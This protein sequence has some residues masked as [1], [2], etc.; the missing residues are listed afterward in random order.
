[1][2]YLH[3]LFVDKGSGVVPIYH[4]CSNTNKPTE[5]NTMQKVTVKNLEQMAAIINQQLNIEATEAWTRQDD[6]TFKA[7]VGYHYVMSS[8][9]GHSFV[10]IG[11]T[12]GGVTDIFSG[13]TKR[14]LIQQM[15]AYS[16]G[17][18]HVIK[19]EG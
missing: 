4:Q 7:N 5:G 1:V 18:A 9:F 13:N 3:Y 19:R 6:G 8:G 12:G 10:R 15:R 2:K 11:N 16:V 17:L 14:E